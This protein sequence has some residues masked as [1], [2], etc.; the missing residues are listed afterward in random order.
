MRSA[1]VNKLYCTD[2]YCEW[3]SYLQY[4]RV[5]HLA[6]LAVVYGVHP[7]SCEGCGGRIGAWHDF[8]DC[9][10]DVRFS[11]C[12]QRASAIASDAIVS[13]HSA[14][15]AAIRRIWTDCESSPA[16]FPIRSTSALGQRYRRGL[17]GRFSCGRHWN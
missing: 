6:F 13:S 7:T 4:P 14:M 17:R 1:L 3:V 2:V 16:L 5:V 12:I 8:D 15:S 10:F 9:V 11:K